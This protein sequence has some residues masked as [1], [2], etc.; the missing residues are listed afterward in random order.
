MSDTT[1]SDKQLERIRKLLA[2]AEHPGTGPKEAEHASEQAIRLMAKYGVERAMLADAGQLRDDITTRCIVISAPYE[3]DKNVLLNAIATAKNCRTVYS[4]RGGTR[5]VQIVGYACDVELVWM[6]YGSLLLQMKNAVSSRKP[7]PGVATI[8]FRKSLTAGFA[9]S[10]SARLQA[11]LKDASTQE[12][13]S[14]SGRSVELVL[15]DRAALVDQ[16]FDRLHP[17]VATGR[18]RTLR[19]AAGWNAGMEEGNR[20]DI[21]QTRV[22]GDQRRR[23]T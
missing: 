7:P 9:A 6:L 5:T 1:A 21:G 14:E 2:L 15:R 17:D 12:S 3:V 19:S 4:G 10:V 20:A 18:A 23:L 8:T 16:E 13:P 11:A 22:G